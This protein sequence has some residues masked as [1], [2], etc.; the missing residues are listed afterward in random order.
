M[1]KIDLFS[2]MYEFYSWTGVFSGLLAG[3]L[4]FYGDVLW[5]FVVLYPLDIGMLMLS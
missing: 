3:L 2:L 4:P 5:A 1:N